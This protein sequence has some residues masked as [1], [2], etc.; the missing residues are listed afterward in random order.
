MR[1]YCLDLVS[2]ILTFE[3]LMVFDCKLQ[4]T[5]HAG[6][7]HALIGKHAPLIEDTHREYH[8]GGLNIVKV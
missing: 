8:D 5:Y 1:K 6:F 7:D 4:F 3:T 2:V